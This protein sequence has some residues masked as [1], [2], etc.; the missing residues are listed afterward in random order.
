MPLIW[1][2]LAILILVLAAGPLRRK[3]LAN[4]PFI[5]PAI[6]G[7]VFAVVMI[8][9]VMKMN[10]PGLMVLGISTIVAIEAGVIGLQWFNETFGSNKQ[11]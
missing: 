6:A 8:R 11:R 9:G 2:L 7:F 4:W 3:M 10:L 5:L 1:I